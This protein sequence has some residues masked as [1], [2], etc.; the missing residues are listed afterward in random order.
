MT[1]SSGSSKSASSSSSS[2]LSSSSSSFLSSSSGLS[3]SGLSSSGFS[4]SG[5]S[6]SGSSSLSSSSSSSYSCPYIDWEFSAN[7]T[8]DWTP[9]LGNH[10][11][12]LR[13]QAS[14]DVGG[15][16]GGCGGTNTSPQS[17]TATGT[18]IVPIGKVM[19]VDW[20]LEAIV[21]QDSYD[22]DN[23]YYE[24]DGVIQIERIISD[25]DGLGCTNG[26]KKTLTGTTILTA[27]THTLAITYDTFDG[28]FHK[29]NYGVDFKI[30]SCN[31]S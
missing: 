21:E 7:N 5:M 11:V 12:E 6:A 15:G 31:L 14:G 28:R 13:I 9:G 26:I 2:E 1:S 25:G 17:G 8:N 24:V 3:R 29:D 4:S 10:H 27:G 19:T 23:A 20:E 16:A 30:T 22:Y 18:V